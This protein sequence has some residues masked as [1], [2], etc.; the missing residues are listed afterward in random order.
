MGWCSCGIISSLRFP[1]RLANTF[2]ANYFID[3]YCK[4]EL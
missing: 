2:F 3:Y 1:R 4:N